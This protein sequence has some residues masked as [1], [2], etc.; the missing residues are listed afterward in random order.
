MTTQE[1]PGRP[2]KHWMRKCIKGVTAGKSAA[3]P[4]AV[5]GSLW[6]HKL[7]ES[8]RRAILKEERAGGGLVENPVPGT[9]AARY[10]QEVLSFLAEL[11]HDD[12]TGTRGG[13]NKTET[14]RRAA[15]QVL[16]GDMRGRDT[17]AQESKRISYGTISS[18]VRRSPSDAITIA[19]LIERTPRDRVEAYRKAEIDYQQNPA[20]PYRTWLMGVR[21]QLSRTGYPSTIPPKYERDLRGVYLSGASTKEGAKIMSQ[22]FQGG[23]AANPATG[24]IVAVA[25]ALGLVGVVAYFALRKK[26]EEA[27]PATS[28]TGPGGKPRL[29]PPPSA[30]CV[31]DPGKLQVFAQSKGMLAVYL[32]ACP[33]ATP[34]VQNQPPPATGP[35]WDPAVPPA[36]AALWATVVKAEAP[37]VP[38]L[39]V[40]SDGGFWTYGGS[41]PV[42]TLRT[43][44][45]TAYCEFAAGQFTPVTTPIIN[46]QFAQ[47]DPAALFIL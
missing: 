47:G 37:I 24:T 20:D 29:P 43:D 6:H 34:P 41:P 17:L 39:L 4:G 1:N 12:K 32:P 22:A 10:E 3:D 5:C 15:R 25:A 35:C 31:V 36:W 33:A 13:G 40:L 23:Y 2:P 44:L 7:S 21:R 8:Q 30:A 9:L 18:S 11:S 46:Y 42:A 14:V 19:E 16:A 27:K 45:R 38:V 28:F 26:E